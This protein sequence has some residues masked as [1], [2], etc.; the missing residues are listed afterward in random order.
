LPDTSSSHDLEVVQPVATMQAIQGGNA[1]AAGLQH[2]ADVH[3]TTSSTVSGTKAARSTTST[4]VTERLSTSGSLH[5]REL[6]PTLR[7]AKAD[8]LV[9]DVGGSWVAKAIRDIESEITLASMQLLEQYSVDSV[10]TTRFC[11]EPTPELAR[12]YC[13]MLG[14]DA[15]RARVNA[16]QYRVPT[17]D[18]SAHEIPGALIGASLHVEV[19]TAEAFPWDVSSRVLAALGKDRQ[20]LEASAQAIGYELKH[21]LG[22]ASRKQIMDDTFCHS[23]IAAHAEMLS[24]KF[25]Q[26]I[27]PHLQRMKLRGPAYAAASAYEE[28]LKGIYER[29][30][31]LKQKMEYSDVASYSA[32]WCPSVHTFDRQQHQSGLDGQSSG[33]IAF[34]TLSGI[35]KVTA[36]SRTWAAKVRVVLETAS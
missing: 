24:Q 7:P 29:A 13:K 11:I 2:A 6:S 23:T 25:I 8:Y 19:F 28:C 36:H 1:K 18:L 31:V 35:E 10:S 15:W 33:Q 26:I 32:V 3:S 4:P 17:L 14:T 22:L 27:L 20:Y 21:V 16:L 5:D 30:L 9:L 12:L 34:T